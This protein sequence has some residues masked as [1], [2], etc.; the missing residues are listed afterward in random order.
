M[1]F[2]DPR[3]RQTFQHIS[4]NL[5]SA[6]ETAQEGFY[7]FSQTCIDPC[8]AGI[9]NC[10]TS[11]SAPCFPSRED[12]LRR[13]RGRSRGRA[14]LNFDFYDDWDDD[15][16]AGDGLLGW[17]N[18]ELDRLLAGSSSTGSRRGRSDQ[19]RRQ[20]AM[21]YGSRGQRKNSILPNDPSTDPTI[22]PS[23]SFLGFLDRLPWKI[24]GRSLR[25]KP[26]AADLQDNPGGLR[27]WQGEGEPLIEASDESDPGIRTKQWRK[28]SGTTASQSTTN[29]LSSRGDLIPSDEED[30]AV[31]L[32]DEFAV[33]LERRT[34][35][36][37][38]DD[39]SSGKTGS[40]RRPGASRAST[41]TAS[42]K[43]TRVTGKGRQQS[44]P[45]EAESPQPTIDPPP[46][47]PTIADLEHEEEQ[48]RAEED[49]EIEIK[50]QAAQSLA[51]QRGLGSANNDKVRKFF[52][53]LTA[54]CDLTNDG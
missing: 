6:N 3:I 7:T 29:S 43:D 52:L 13:K 15:E 36:T 46:G 30:D 31:P 16:D 20:R 39:H 9:K 38:S 1:A 12:Q 49:R 21:S 32:D 5:E 27:R 25:Y 40:G 28:R 35:G 37:L 26:S 24:G 34:T 33:A 45:R 41:R 23:S 14:E 42:S 19:P 53:P 54:T 22:I 18:D 2:T 47:I 44:S 51:A 17:G 8:V 11:C 10:V 48:A 50:R 4:Q